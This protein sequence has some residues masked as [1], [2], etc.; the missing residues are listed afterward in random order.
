LLRAF[1]SVK[2][3]R[4]ASVQELSELP[5]ISRQLAEHLLAEL[6]RAVD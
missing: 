4:A 5:G 1:G 3:I 2:K 6:Q